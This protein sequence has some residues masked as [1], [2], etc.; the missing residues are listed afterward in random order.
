MARGLTRAC[1]RGADVTELP[2]CAAV[3]LYSGMEHHHERLAEC[4]FDSR[5]AECGFVH[6]AAELH[7]VLGKWLRPEEL[8]HDSLPVIVTYA[9]VGKRWSPLT[10]AAES[11]ALRNEGWT[12]QYGLYAARDFSGGECLGAMSDGVRLGPRVSE[13][14]LRSLSGEQRRF[15]CSFGRGNPT[16]A[17]VFDC[18]GCREG[19]PKRAND[20]RGLGARANAVMYENGLL[21]VGAFSSIPGLRAEDP[22]ARRARAEILWHYGAAFWA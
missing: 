21:C 13:A 19:G 3:T 9:Q 6:E 16:G 14:A 11:E 4:I 7:P 17:G 5:A 22:P 18:S 12:A 2:P 10:I 20:P 1:T 8:L 15:V